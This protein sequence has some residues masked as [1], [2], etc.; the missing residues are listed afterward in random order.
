MW[1]PQIRVDDRRG[2]HNQPGW[3]DLG[4]GAI[5]ANAG[6]QRGGEAHQHRLHVADFVNYRGVCLAIR[7]DAEGERV[8]G[9]LTV[10]LDDQLCGTGEVKL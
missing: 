8:R 2:V 7:H 10:H 3:F 4:C 5:P 6:G 1:F 9:E